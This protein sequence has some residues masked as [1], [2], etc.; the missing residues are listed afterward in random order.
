MNIVPSHE[1]VPLEA[2]SPFELRASLGQGV[3]ESAIKRA[4]QTGDMGFLHSFTTGSTVDG[5][6]VRLVAWAAGCQ[7]RCLYCHNPDTWNMMN[8]M[9][10][11]LDRAIEEL[12]KYR[13][14]LKIMSG[15]F[16]LSGGEPLA[17]DRFAVRLFTA[18]KSLGIHTALD[19][20]GYLGER[21]SDDELDRIDVVLLD[22]KCWNP[23]RHLHLTGKAVGPTLDFAR[24]LAQCRRTVWLRY[25]LVPGLSDDEGDIN[26]I[27]AFT[28]GLGNVERVDVLPFHN[29]GRYKWKELGVPYTLTDVQPPTADLVDRTCKQFRAVGLTA[30]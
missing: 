22:I 4:L 23:E 30:F 15:G 2:R 29:L 8:G 24:R 17:Q 12:A 16:T 3:S 1:Q 5:P 28:A 18:A 11:T 14:G 19:T 9:P 21:L 20:N 26:Q 25:V 13:H 6:G 27:A 10:V 7:W